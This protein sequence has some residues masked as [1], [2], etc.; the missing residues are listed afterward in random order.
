MI[1]LQFGFAAA[2]MNVVDGRLVVTL[3]RQRVPVKSDSRTV[4]YKSAY[5][6]S[7]WVGAPEP[8]EFSVVFDTGSG[9]VI[10]PSAD[11]MAGTCR[12]HRRYERKLSDLAIDVDYDGTTVKPG[13]PR[14]QITVSF[15]TGEV[16]GEFVQDTVCLGQKSLTRPSD[17]LA[18]KNASN[19]PE[20]Q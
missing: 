1:M 4:S 8:Q 15:G 13:Q 17:D 10:I 11:C 9:H 20:L 2:D 12:I 7:I 3:Q 18:A 16:T 5:F 6:G 19:Y 14:D